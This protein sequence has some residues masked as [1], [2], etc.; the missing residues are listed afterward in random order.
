MLSVLCKPNVYVTR[1]DAPPVI[2]TESTKGYKAMKAKLGSSKV[3]PWSWMP[4]QNPARK[5]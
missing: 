1:R 2:A 4:F 3:R 5:V